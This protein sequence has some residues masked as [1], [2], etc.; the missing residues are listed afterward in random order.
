MPPILAKM[1]LLSDNFEN[2]PFWTK[3]PLFGRK[4]RKYP[5]LFENPEARTFGQISPF[6]AQKTRYSPWWALAKCL[7]CLCLNP[8]LDSIILFSEILD[9]GSAPLKSTNNRSI[10]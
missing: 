5:I 10:G 2:T 4:F 3:R 9:L 8:A 1:P 7:L 6:L